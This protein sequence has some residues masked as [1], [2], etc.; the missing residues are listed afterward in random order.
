M[1]KRLEGKHILV[2]AA[3]Q[4][5]GKASVLALAAEGAKVLATDVNESLL[6][7]YRGVDG[8]T[9]ARLDVLDDAAVTRMCLPSS[10][11]AMTSPFCAATGRDR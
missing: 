2:T 5:I 3:G 11:L 7:G 8:V 6:Q 9:T 1:A 10:L 4:G